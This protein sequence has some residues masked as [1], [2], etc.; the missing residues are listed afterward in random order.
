MPGNGA[1]RVE[2]VGGAPDGTHRQNDDFPAAFAQR[3]VF[4]LGN[5]QRSE[6][7][8]DSRCEQCRIERPYQTA[9]FGARL[10]VRVLCPRDRHIH[11]PVVELFLLWGERIAL[12][13]RKAAAQAAAV[14]R[15]R[16]SL[17]CCELSFPCSQDAAD[18]D[19]CRYRQLESAYPASRNHPAGTATIPVTDSA[20]MR[21]TFRSLK[22][23]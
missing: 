20:A 19:V 1:V 17:A 22:Q 21:P 15:H 8:R 11:Q 16:L 2:L 14:V 12:V 5:G 10:K 18:T 4:L 9:A 7:R 13:K 3:R 6:R 23:L